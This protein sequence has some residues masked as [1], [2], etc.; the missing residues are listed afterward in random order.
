MDVNLGSI[1]RERRG[2]RESNR[3]DHCLSLGGRER[4]EIPGGRTNLE[5]SRSKSSSM[6]TRFSFP[7]LKASDSETRFF[8]LDL[9]V[10]I[11]RSW[12]WKAKPFE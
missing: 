5:R 1:E 7:I 8:P 11:L 10:D 3:W 9:A 12:N 4:E 6:A 2:L